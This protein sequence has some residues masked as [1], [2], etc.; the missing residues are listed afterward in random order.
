MRLEYNQ[1][2]PFLSAFAGI[3]NSPFSNT[4]EMTPE[5]LC[6][7]ACVRVCKHVDP[8]RCGLRRNI[9]IQ[10]SC[11]GHRNVDRLPLPMEMRH[12]GHKLIELLH[13]LCRTNVLLREYGNSAFFIELRFR[14]RGIHAKVSG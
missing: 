13:G 2:P 12:I 6:M 9:I 7:R 8:A 14:R 1:C 5:F 4:L 10:E 3:I 11:V